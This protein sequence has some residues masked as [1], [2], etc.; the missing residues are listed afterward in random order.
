MNPKMSSNNKDNYGLVAVSPSVCP[1]DGPTNW[2]PA[3]PM[4][5]GSLMRHSNDE[6]AEEMIF[7]VVA[8]S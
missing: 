1:T 7:L 8:I 2:Q 3:E 6:I 4:F 5:G